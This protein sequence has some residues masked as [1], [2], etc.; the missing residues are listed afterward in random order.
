VKEACR[1]SRGTIWVGSIRQD[2]RFGARILARS[3]GF[4]ATAILVLAL[5]IG[6]CTLGFSLFNLV[7]LQSIPVRNP[8]TLVGTQRQ[9][10]ENIAPNVPYTSLAFYSDH[11]K[12]LSAV[13]G[14]MI[15]TPMVL[16]RNEQ[17]LKP[18][19][20]TANYFAELGASAAVGRLFDRVRENT[21]G[22]APVVV[23]SYRL[24]QRSFAGDSSV[25]GRSILL[26][27]RPATVIGVTAQGFANP[28]MDDPD[29]YL[30]L[31]QHGY[32][33]VGSKALNDPKFDGMLKMWARLAPGMT[34]SQ[35]QQDLLAMT[36]QMRP[37]YPAV[38]WDGERIELSPGAHFFTL[39]EGAPI[40]K[41]VGVLVL[42]ILAVACANLG[43][44]L[45]ARGGG[46]QREI[47]MR[48]NLGAR[49]MRVFRQLLTESLLLG[50]LGA[51]A[52]LPLSY[53]ALH[54]ALLYAHAPGWMSAVPDWRVLAFTAFMG[55]IAALFF[56]LLP[57]LQMVRARRGKMR[58]T[59]FV[60]GAQVAAS[61][62]LLILAGLL[63]RATM[64]TLYSNPG[65]HYE[66]VLA[67][68]PDLGGHGYTPARA[69]AYLDAMQS[70]LR[71]ATG[72]ESVALA[73]SPP[74]VNEDVMTT[75]IS[76]DG[77][78]VMV[79]PNWV[80]SQFFKTLGVPLLGGR[81]MRAG[82]EHVVVLSESLA[83]RRWPK[84]DPIGKQWES[85]K[86]T[87]IGVVGNTRA[88]EL[89]NTDATEIY[90][91]AESER[92]PAMSIL[93]KTVGAAPPIL[94]ISRS[95]DPKLF[96]SITPLSAGFRKSAAQAEQ[97]AALVSLLGAI[98]IFL[99]AVG[100]LGLVAYAVTQRTREIA[101]RLA[102]GASRPEIFATILRH[103]A[104]P[105]VT[106][107]LLGVAAT[108]ALSQVIRRGLFGISGLDPV[109]YVVAILLL[110]VVLAA[111]ALIPI[112]HA[113]RLDV[114]RILQAD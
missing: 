85:G 64:H 34:Q 104:W 41:V 28:G 31:A 39:E 8:E 49:R 66:Q 38:I 92:M 58:G 108:A 15:D 9:S 12:T 57:T 44:L 103:F 96:P 2:L 50:L 47:Q 87:V 19:F 68:N 36:N 17:R 97:I 88:M 18:S 27:G 54:E 76:V 77:R 46:R 40:A 82:E 11:A 52:A 84:E 67:I 24:W 26:G 22:S 114:A 74:L 100:L 32:F 13:M 1:E 94:A 89:N 79:Y 63:V 112:R 30:P 110:L 113:F 109:S 80:D 98:A 91:P 33:V 14:T 86:D 111:A 43:G 16:D 70:R 51:I 72:V 29:L 105:V 69:E 42:L 5:G 99:A 56:G 35:A 101:I 7:V 102:L 48:L 25:V 95:L 93:I 73:L 53:A 106:G 6:V 83:R 107:L 61:C 55:F 62:V 59:H 23:L 90:Y 4:T 37:L 45:M 20:V 21:V 65:F 78:R 81:L 10:P 60:V 71:Y 75:D 3:P